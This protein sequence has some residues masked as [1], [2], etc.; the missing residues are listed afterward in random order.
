VLA[1]KYWYHYRNPCTHY[2]GQLSHDA[3]HSSST[4]SPIT[5][6]FGQNFSIRDADLLALFVNQVHFLEIGS[7]CLYCSNVKV[8]ESLQLRGSTDGAAVVSTVGVV[9]PVGLNDGD[10]DSHSLHA[11][12]HSSKTQEPS[13]KVSQY[14]FVR[15]FTFDAL[16][17]SQLHLR[18]LRNP[19]CG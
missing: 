1:P 8:V 7:P 11:T 3:L 19:L 14:L 17:V 16:A 15:K 18:S 10:A 5:V 6:T 12:G 4:T 9:V 2:D 13:E